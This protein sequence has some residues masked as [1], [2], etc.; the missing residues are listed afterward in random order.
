M[1]Q[2]QITHEEIKRFGNKLQSCFRLFGTYTDLRVLATLTDE[3]VFWQLLFRE[4]DL[5]ILNWMIDNP[6]MAPAGFTQQS[7][8]ISAFVQQAIAIHK[9][10]ENKYLSELLSDDDEG[11]ATAWEAIINEYGI[12]GAKQYAIEHIQVETEQQKKILINGYHN[13]K[14]RLG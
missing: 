13:A 14:R 6:H 4:Y 3:D 9:R 10:A 2:A 11:I 12:E 8:K 5:P 1:T 7:A